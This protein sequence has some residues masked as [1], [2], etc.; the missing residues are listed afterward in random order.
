MALSKKEQNKPCEF[1]SVNNYLFSKSKVAQE[2]LWTSQC[3]KIIIIK[4]LIGLITGLESHVEWN[5]IHS[6]VKTTMAKR[7]NTNFIKKDWNCTEIN[8]KTKT[9]LLSLYSQGQ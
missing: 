8:T 9:F 2:P 4:I 5:S 6:I 3:S 1:Q 7:N